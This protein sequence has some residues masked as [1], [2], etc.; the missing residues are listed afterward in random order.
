MRHSFLVSV[1]A[2]ALATCGGAAALAKPVPAPSIVHAPGPAGPISSGRTAPPKAA[3]DTEVLFKGDDTVGALLMPTS[4]LIFL[5]SNRGPYD[6][7]V[8]YGRVTYR[9]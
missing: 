2:A 9:F 6:V 1:I 3:T 4:P 5:T 8:V 7:N